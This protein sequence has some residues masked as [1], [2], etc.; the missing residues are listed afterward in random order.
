[1]LF[2]DKTKIEKQNRDHNKKQVLSLSL[3]DHLL[4]FI[5]LKNQKLKIVYD[6][7]S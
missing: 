3:S 5:T 1:M 7:P 6:K 2:F 4:E